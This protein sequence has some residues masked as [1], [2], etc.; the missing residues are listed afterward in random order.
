MAKILDATDTTF[1]QKVLKSQ[2][3]VLVDFWAE[4]CAP[5]RQLAPVIKEL[6][7]EYGD[8]LLVAK[9]DVDANPATAAKLQVRAMPTLI[10]IKNGTVSSAL[11]GR[12]PKDKIKEQIESML[13]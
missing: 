4:W 10:F 1:E 3:P 13:V 2:T 5:C 7:E 6:A 12:Q 11:V 9:V 8:R